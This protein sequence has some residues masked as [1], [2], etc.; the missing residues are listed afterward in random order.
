M[1][2][3]DALRVLAD[4]T[5]SQ[6]GL[7][8]AAQAGA[9]GVTRLMLS[10]LAE[11]GHLERLAH[12]V[13]KDAGAPSDEFEDLHAAW[14]STEPKALG[15]RRLQDP[16]DDVVVA[17]AS[18]ARL[19]GIGD[20]WAERHEFVSSSRR[21]TQRTELRYRRRTLDARDVTMVRGLPSMTLERTIADLLEDVGDLSLVA[22]ALGAAL[23]KQ[24]LDLE[25]L[26]DLLAPLAER[27]GFTRH[28]GQAVLDRLLEEA[29]LDAN[30]VARRVAADPALGALIM[31]NYLPRIDP[32]IFRQ[33]A[34][35]S[36]VQQALRPVLVSLART[37]RVSVTPRLAVAQANADAALAGLLS[38]G[39]ADQSGRI[40]ERPVNAPALRNA[41]EQRAKTLPHED[42]PAARRDAAPIDQ[43]TSHGDRT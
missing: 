31:S 23:E 34:A 25:R 39:L 6:W 8:T 12:G 36:E 24:S 4:I 28:A 43:E 9:L 7:V 15:E 13:Y 22:D 14:L 16:T 32:A 2:S 18:A 1:K 21:Q 29:G 19:H 26:R 33:L 20:L 41:A 5:A 27:N 17:G 10:R 11:A 40:T 30:A 3:T 42:L 37:L 38:S 35:V